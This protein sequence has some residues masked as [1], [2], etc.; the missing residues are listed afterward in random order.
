MLNS[1]QIKR[2]TS[3]LDL[4]WRGSNKILTVS[5]CIYLLILIYIG[6]ETLLT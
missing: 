2:Y 3:P 5:I 6:H 1:I 4:N